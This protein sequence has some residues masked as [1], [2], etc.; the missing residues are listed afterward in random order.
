MV[1][2]DIWLPYKTILLQN[3]YSVFSAQIRWRAFEIRWPIIIKQAIIVLSLS[4]IDLKWKTAMI[5]A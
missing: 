5:D 1:S 2:R 3:S 4:V